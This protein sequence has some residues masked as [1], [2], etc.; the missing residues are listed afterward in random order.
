MHADGSRTLSLSGKLSNI[1]IAS[2]RYFFIFS[3]LSEDG[4]HSLIVSFMLFSS[5][6]FVYTLSLILSCFIP[7][8]RKQVET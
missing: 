8:L 7:C 5:I 3:N 4:F 6:F 2:M 1:H